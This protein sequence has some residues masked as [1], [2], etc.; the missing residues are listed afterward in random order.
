MMLGART[1][2]W[3]GGAKWTNPYVTDGQF[4]YW[5]AEWNAG[6][7]IHDEQKRL[8]NLL[9]RDHEL[10]LPS[11]ATLQSKCVLFGSYGAYSNRPAGEYLK[12]ATGWSICSTIDLSQTQEKFKGGPIFGIGDQ[13]VL[14][15]PMRDDYLCKFWTYS[16][17]QGIGTTGF[18]YVFVKT[19]YDGTHNY[20]MTCDIQNE[21]TKV[22]VD[23]KY[24]GSIDKAGIVG[25]QYIHYG[26]CGY[27]MM[28]SGGYQRDDP[29]S[30]SIGVKVY[31]EM[32]YTRPLTTAEV[33]ANYAVDKARFNLP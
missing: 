32:F 12:F 11:S 24:F 18:G 23:G 17:F 14:E 1:G 5:D 19:A 22:Y 15:Q 3:S 16:G 27:G 33:S 20:C 13:N 25:D 2:A 10:A 9:S 21:T 8:V 26:R 7:G 28:C 4:I 6:G 31:N 30:L 29:S